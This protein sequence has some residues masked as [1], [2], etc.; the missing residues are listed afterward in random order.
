MMKVIDLEM[1]CEMLP[2]TTL[3]DRHISRTL[4]MKLTPFLLTRIPFFLNGETFHC[5]YVL[6]G[7]GRRVGS[8]DL[9]GV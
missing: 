2:V 5:L 8:A 4:D 7:S 9:G 6:C 3:L 1:G